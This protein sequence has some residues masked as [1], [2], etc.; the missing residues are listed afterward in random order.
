MPF[1]TAHNWK[2][3]LSINKVK[4]NNQ[5]VNR[6]QTHYKATIVF[7][8]TSKFVKRVNSFNGIGGKILAVLALKTPF[9]G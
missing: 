9:D 5:L 6:L 1:Q 7:V 4:L 2:I 3:K 8:E